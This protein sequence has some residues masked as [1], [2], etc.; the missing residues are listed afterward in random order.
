V[1]GRPDYLP[2][3]EA[4]ATYSKSPYAVTK[5]ATEYYS[6]VY[7]DL[8]GLPTVSLRNFTMYGP[9]MRP[10]TAITNFGSRCLDREPPVV[11]GDGDQ[12]RDFTYID[13]AIDVNRALLETDAVDGEALNVVSTDNIKIREFA[14]HVIAETGSDVETV[15]EDAKDADARPTHSDVSKARELL[16]YEPS[17]GIRE[18]L[19][20]F[21]DWYEDNREWYR[22]MA[23]QS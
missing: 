20:L 10:N 18:G 21:I 14:E 22:P 4:R 3:D 2:Y 9:R 8:H 5:L 7:Y 1:Y 11:Y 17:I 19:S 15:H 13:D 12:T 16:G 6:K 23:L